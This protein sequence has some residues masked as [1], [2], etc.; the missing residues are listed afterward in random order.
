MSE[1]KKTKKSHYIS[2]KES[3]K[4]SRQNAKI[5]K[6]FEKRKKRRN[7]ESEYVTEM[8]DPTNI[9]ELK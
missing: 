3:R 9:P 1:E 2:G 4:I 7:V 6:K 5:T 8:K